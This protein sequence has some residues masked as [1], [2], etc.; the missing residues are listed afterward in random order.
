MSGVPAGSPSSDIHA[1]LGDSLIIRSARRD[2]AAA[3]AA[4]VYNAHAAKGNANASAGAW[5][6]DLMER[7]HPT[8][9]V[10]DVLVV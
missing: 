10:E 4:L 8:M 5:V 9:T 3:V 1:D 7:P 6:L 2:D